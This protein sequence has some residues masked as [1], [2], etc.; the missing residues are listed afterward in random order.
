MTTAGTDIFRS[1]TA[2]EYAQLAASPATVFDSAAF[3]ALNASKV[4]R[5]SYFAGHG[6]CIAAGLGDDGLWRAP[7]S[8]PFSMPTATGVC[9]PDFKAFA[10]D[11]HAAVEGRI[12]LILPPPIHRHVGL[13][14]EALRTLPLACITD[15]SY[16]YPLSQA[17]DY[18]A[19]LR[20]SQRRYLRKSMQVPYTFDSRTSLEEA[21]NFIAVQH[22]K[23]NYHM[24]MSLK[25]VLDTA[26]IIDVDVL[27]LRLEGCLMA[28][29]YFFHVN[30]GIVQMINWDDN[31]EYRH[32]RPMPSFVRHVM[33]HYASKNNV[34]ILDLGPASTDGVKND[35]LVRFKLSIGAVE[36]EKLTFLPHDCVPD[37]AHP[38]KNA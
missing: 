8:A 23:L 1:I 32:L 25:Q 31:V 29:G 34:K 6:L 2:D 13:W 14:T 36:T 7:F 20:P 10:R 17:V 3:N 27:S 4:S 35:G 28:A 38:Q 33:E 5:V 22:N 18:M 11:L 12:R 15:F 30:D 24:A 16:H 37:T 26:Q 21:Y 9:S 19:H